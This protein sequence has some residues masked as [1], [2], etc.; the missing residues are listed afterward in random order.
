MTSSSQTRWPQLAEVCG[1]DDVPPERDIGVVGSAQLEVMQALWRHYLRPD[2]LGT[3]EHPNNFL[4]VLWCSVDA[5]RK[6]AIDLELQVNV[7]DRGHCAV[8][9][10]PKS[11]LIAHVRFLDRDGHPYLVVDQK[12]FDDLQR[13]AFSIYGL[14]D[15]AGMKKYLSQSGSV[16]DGTITSL[17]ERIDRVAAENQ[18]CAFISLADSMVVKT[19]WSAGAGGYEATYQPEKFI[20]LLGTVSEVFASVF[21]MPAYA[22]ATQGSNQCGDG[23]LIHVS[24]E[25]NHVLIPSLATPFA[26]LFE[27]ERAARSATKLRIHRPSPLYLSK[28]L[29]QSL[30]FKGHSTPSVLVERLIKHE[31][32][33]VSTESSFYLP[34]SEAELRGFLA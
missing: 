4:N 33:V 29:F 22:V 11:K 6:K 8:R 34:T 20:A 16:P 10:L 30:R 32:E 31:S 5:S 1:S 12:W 15:V 24:K 28:S 14:V 17:R 18:H 7:R 21:G 13:S 27:I 3:D 26:E 9:T 25:G 2:S 23:T 19:N